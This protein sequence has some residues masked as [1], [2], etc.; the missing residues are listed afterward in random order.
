MHEKLHLFV[1]TLRDESGP[2]PPSNGFELIRIVQSLFG[3]SFI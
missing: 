3:V 1:V 2:S